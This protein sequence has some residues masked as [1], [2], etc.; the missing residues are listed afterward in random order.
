MSTWD[1]RQGAETPT[2]LPCQPQDDFLSPGNA[3]VLGPGILLDGVENDRKPPVEPSSITNGYLAYAV[4]QVAERKAHFSRPAPD[5]RVVVECISD[6]L[7]LKSVS[8]G[9]KAAMHIFFARHR[10]GVIGSIQSVVRNSAVAQDLV[11]YVFLDV[12]RSARKFENRSRVSIWLFQTACFNA[13]GARR[14]RLFEHGEAALRT[15]SDATLV[16]K[17]PNDILQACVDRL[18]PAHRE[19]IEMI[20]FR[21]KSIAELSELIG[22]PYAT[23]RGRLFYARKQLARMLAAACVT[24]ASN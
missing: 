20:Y 12:W 17:E 18:T 2:R 21:K 23:M 15:A 13:V 5:C 16:A 8:D 24:C 1:G 10:M 11:G 14:S 22:I 4:Y 9:S 19:V 7:L 6:E 3:P